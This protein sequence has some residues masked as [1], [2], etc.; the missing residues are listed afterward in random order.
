MIKFIRVVKHQDHGKL[1]WFRLF[2]DGQLVTSFEIPDDCADKFEDDTKLAAKLLA[3]I[4]NDD[5]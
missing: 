4:Q 1:T 5:E 2:V 3:V